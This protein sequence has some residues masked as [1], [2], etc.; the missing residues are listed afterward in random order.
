ML[1]TIFAHAIFVPLHLVCRGAQRALWRVAAQDHQRCEIYADALA[2][3]L[4]GTRGAAELAHVLLFR[5]PVVRALR[6]VADTSADPQV[7]QAEVAR[8]LSRRRRPASSP[9]SGR[10]AY[11]VSAYASHPPSGLRSRLVRSWPSTAP[12]IRIP[13]EAMAAADRDLGRRYTSARRAHRQPLG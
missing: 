1:A 3:R 6:E 7:W 11:D 9:N 4:G 10:C 12:A 8:T 2:V 13:V 5:D